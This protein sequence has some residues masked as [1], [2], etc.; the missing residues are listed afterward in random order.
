[1]WRHRGYIVYQKSKHRYF[2][3]FFVLHFASHGDR[4]H[5]LETWHL[6]SGWWRNSEG[7]GCQSCL[8]GVS[9]ASVDKNSYLFLAVSEKYRAQFMTRFELIRI[10]SN[11]IVITH[12]HSLL[13]DQSVTWSLD[14]S[15]TWLL[16][17]LF[18][19]QTWIQRVCMYMYYISLYHLRMGLRRRDANFTDSNSMSNSDCS[20][21]AAAPW[22]ACTE[23][24]D[25]FGIKRICADW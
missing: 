25:F 24:V 17:S 21:S 12:L 18:P 1:M 9:I 6:V 4:V 14:H 3:F 23:Y 11:R 10:E 15:I 16:G 2:E 22:Q 19:V 5:L 8:A 20:T 13:S 7:A